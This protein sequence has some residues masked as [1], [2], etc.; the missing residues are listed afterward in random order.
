MYGRLV[1]VLDANTDVRCLTPPVTAATLTRSNAEVACSLNVRT[2]S[3]GG[4]NPL[5]GGTTFSI[6]PEH[7]W[8][9]QRYAF[10]L[11]R[12]AFANPSPRA[13]HVHSYNVALHA[14]SIHQP[15]LQ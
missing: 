15:S 10:T 11:L 7:G 4:D 8:V 14:Q 1:R 5:V 12:V 6:T 2:N 13:L 3:T 9:C